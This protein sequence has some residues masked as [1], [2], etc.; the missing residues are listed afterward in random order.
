[1]PRQRERMPDTYRGKRMPLFVIGSSFMVLLAVTIS[2]QLSSPAGALVRIQ[3]AGAGGA[4]GGTS[5]ASGVTQFA[6]LFTNTQR[7]ITGNQF[8]LNNGYSNC[9]SEDFSSLV[10]YYS[11]TGLSCT[12]LQYDNEITRI[13]PCDFV[14]EYAITQ[15]ESTGA[16]TEPQAGDRN[17]FHQTVTVTCAR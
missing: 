3:D 11:S 2:S 12:G 16:T 6:T 5:P 15:C 13:Y 17:E 10:S 8:C 1:M 14:L 7:G 9:I 4:G